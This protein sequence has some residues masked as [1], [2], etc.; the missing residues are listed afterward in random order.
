MKILEAIETLN[1]FYKEVGNVDLVNCT[2]VDG[3]FI[4]EDRELDI[5]EIPTDD[6]EYIYDT[7]VAFL[8]K[9]LENNTERPKLVIIKK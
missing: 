1:K 7:V 3:E 8:E 6:N 5:I 2:E 4:I 9:D